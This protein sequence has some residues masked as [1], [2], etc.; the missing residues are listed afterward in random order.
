[1][2]SL[3]DFPNDANGDVLRHMRESG[4][5][6]SVAR[7]IDFTV[8]FASRDE[9]QKFG[10]HF[11]RLGYRVSANKSGCVEDLPWDVVVVKNMVPTHSGITTFEAELQSAATPLGGR[12]DG[13]GCFE[14]L[15]SP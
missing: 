13:W 10:D 11:H 3:D 5:D 4:D 8:V 12:N 14:Q 2:V 1:M 7:N 9:V 6:L 15:P